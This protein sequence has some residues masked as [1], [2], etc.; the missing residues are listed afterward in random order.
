MTKPVTSDGDVVTE[1]AAYLSQPTLMIY[2]ATG[3]T[4]RLV[5]AQAVEFGLRP[6][7]AGRNAE[8]LASM[9]RTFGLEAHAFDLD[10]TERLATALGDITVV[11]HCAGPFSHTA[12]PMLEACLKTGTHYLDI[13]GEIAVFE[14]LAARDAAA[15][16]ANV[17]VLPGVGFDVVP[18]DCLIADLAARYPGGHYMRL[19]LATHSG[20]SR[21]TT[22]TVLENLNNFRIRRDGAITR[23]APGSLRHEFD[24]GEPPRTALVSVLGDVET[25]YRSTGIPNIETYVQTSSRLQVLTRMSRLF[26]RLLAGRLSQYLLN[27]LIDHRPAGPS[28]A[29]RRED[30]TILV[31]EIEDT[32]GKRACARRTPMASPRRRRSPS[33]PVCFAAISRSAIRRHPWRT[34]PT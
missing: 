2:G 5:A 29:D 34:V 21:G 26:G 3:Y 17:M 31:A 13:T 32:N 16:E 11:L 19:G 28:E 1:G 25:A 14:A 4:G 15:K 22:R 7:L 20:L 12:T 6:V 33:Q 27:V 8:K 23:V 24:F 10:D 9:A 30:Y 18:S